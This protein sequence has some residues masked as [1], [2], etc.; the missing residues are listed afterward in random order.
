MAAV[1][2]RAAAGTDNQIKIMSE[3]IL[4]GKSRKT[5][6]WELLCDPSE[7][8]DKHLRIY[9]KIAQSFPVNDEYSK[10]HFGRVQNS[11]APFSLITSAEQ[12][13]RQE[14]EKVR[15]ESYANSRKDA[16]ARQKEINEMAADKERKAH[17]AIIE[18]KTK[19]VNKFR[20]L[21][22]LEAAPVPKRVEP[23]SVEKPAAD[24]ERKE[25]SESEQPIEQKKGTGKGQAA[26]DSLK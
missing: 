19:E 20:K 18:E 24:K 5:G 23:T 11:H 22:G 9:S 13:A 4:I 25:E 6:K 17:E 14:S 16:E 1:Q 2:F 15:A 12:K 7:I 8:Y 3:L 10:V 26:V 21:K